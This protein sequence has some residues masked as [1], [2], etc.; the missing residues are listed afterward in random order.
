ML[1]QGWS[2]EKKEGPGNPWPGHPINID[3][4]INGINGDANGDGEGKEVHTLLLP[5]VVRLQEAY[6]R[7]VIDTVNDLDNVLYEI[8]NESHSGSDAWQKHMIDFI[9]AYEAVKPKQHPVIYSAAL[10]YDG[11][12][13]WRSRAEAISPGW[14]S[15]DPDFVP[16]RDNPPLNDGRKIIINDTDHLWGIGGNHQW[17][18]KSFLR[19]LNPIFM[20]PYTAKEHQNH[21]SKR[22]WELIRKNMGHT[23]TYAIK[24]DL[25]SMVPRNDLCSTKYCLANPGKEYLV[26]LPSRGHRGLRWFDKLGLHKLLG[27]ATKLVGWNE[28]VTVDLLAPS[29]TLHVEWFNP[30]TGETVDGG[31]VKGG[32]RKSLTAPFTGNAVLYIYKP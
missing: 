6:V 1:F 8:A 29:G 16:Y 12:E 9:H 11:T 23:L 2:I 25:A 30:R 10:G 28:K 7:K 21:L 22:E 31:V 20:D 26:Y 27:S 13:L 15:K 14:P 17:V 5:A 19:G 3:N 24:M 32:G 18:W 4:N